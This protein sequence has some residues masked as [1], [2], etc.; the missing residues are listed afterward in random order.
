MST[1][2]F[3]RELDHTAGMRRCGTPEETL[4]R[5][6]PLRP[7]CGITRLARLTGLDDVG[8]PVFAAIRPHARS[9]V[10]SL[11]KGG[12]DAA[13]KVSALMESVEIWHAERVRLPS[14]RG[15]AKFLS[16]RGH[17]VVA[18][19]LL[20]AAAGR[21]VDPAARMDWV[22]GA[23]LQTGEPVWVPSDVVSLDFTSAGDSAAS[24]LL[25]SSNGLA[26]GNTRTEALVHALCEVVER[27][28][29]ALWR[30][31]ADYARVDPD[32][33]TDP[34]CRE[35]IAVLRAAGVGVLLWDVT[36]DIGVP[37]FGCLL[38]PASGDLR[39]VGL[40]DGFGC[41]L[42]PGVA[43]SR[44]LTEAAQNRLTY[45][46]GSRDD[47]SR[48]G[49]RQAVDPDRLAR[50]SAELAA[51]PCTRDFADHKPPETASLAADLDT[52]RARMTAAGF[53]DVVAVDLTYEELG[54]P[55]V[56]VVVP[57]LE[58]RFGDAEPGLRALAESR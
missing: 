54:V 44:A 56:K 27:D 18:A 42:R 16:A 51:V 20:P 33:V 41:H 5:V 21:E 30:R 31:R 12:T 23:D 26:S 8:I 49:L 35:L 17:R 57:G 43:L 4:A 9:L 32:T 24:G 39:A 45:I 52:V 29:E 7:T 3:A 36:S 25:R 47:L 53:A 6:M 11:G 48:E 46:S 13:A 55:V 38:T 19:D 28:A 10:I 50:V 2:G 37:A 15:T 14:R 22:A 34:H 40:H 58:A 1:T